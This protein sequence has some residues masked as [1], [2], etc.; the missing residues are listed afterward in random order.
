MKAKQPVG[1][2]LDSLRIAA[3]LLERASGLLASAGVQ[4]AT[5]RTK[6]ALRTTR[7]A[8]R[9]ALGRALAE[10]RGNRIG[11]KKGA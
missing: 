10:V 6:A 3:G 1:E 5:K 11:K 7:N 8:Y 4:L 9:K 2:S